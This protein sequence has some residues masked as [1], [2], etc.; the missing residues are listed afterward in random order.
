MSEKLPQPNLILPKKGPQTT[1]EVEI[2]PISS[3]QF[4]DIYQ[5]DVSG[6]DGN[7]GMDGHSYYGSEGGFLSF[8]AGADGKHGHPGQPG[9][10]GI[11][12]GHITVGLRLAQTEPETRWGLPYDRHTLLQGHFKRPSAQRQNASADLQLAFNPELLLHANGGQGGRGGDGGRGQDGARGYHGRNATRYSN[13][14]NG[15]PGGDG[16][17]GGR[18]GDGGLGGD[19]GDIVVGV[20]AEQS[21]LLMLVE[22]EVKGGEGGGGGTGGQGG[23][24]GP[25]GS[26]G[27]SYS[28]RE[29]AGND[30]NGNPRYVTR[31]NS[32]GISGRRG[33]NGRRGGDGYKAADG[34]DGSITLVLQNAQGQPIQKARHCFD[35]AIT[36][37][38][39]RDAYGDQIWEPGERIYLSE[40]TVQN[41]GQIPLPPQ[42]NAYLYL[43]NNDRILSEAIAL[44]LPPSLAPGAA[45]TFA[46]ELAVHLRRPKDS[47]ITEEPFRTTATIDPGAVMGGIQKTFRN[48][49][50]NTDLPVQFPI[51]SGPIYG[52]HAIAKGEAT[53]IKW[54][55]ANHSATDQGYLSEMKRQIETHFRFIPSE[56]PDALPWEHILLFDKFGRRMDIPEGLVQE[57]P[58]LFAKE[59][60]EAANNILEQAAFIAIHPDARPMTTAMSISELRFAHPDHPDSLERIQIP[61]FQVRVAKKY[62]KTPGSD[63][64]LV[65]NKDTHIRTVQ[66]VLAYYK[67][68][69]SEVDIW[70]VAH[71]GLLNLEHQQENG[72]SLM[73]DFEGKTV[74]ILNND[75]K[76][77]QGSE[78]YSSQLVDKRQFLRAANDYGINF[79]LLGRTEFQGED[80]RDALQIPSSE[81]E[82]ISWYDGRRATR[83]ALKRRIEEGIQTDEGVLSAPLGDIA[84][85]VDNFSNRAIGWRASGRLFLWA[86][87]RF[88]AKR[89]RKKT[90]QLLQLL[91]KRYPHER[92]IGVYDW[93]VKEKG[94]VLGGLWGKVEWGSVIFR[95]GPHRLHGGRMVSVR[96]SEK[97]LVDGSFFKTPDAPFQ[98]AIGLTIWESRELFERFLTEQSEV[99]TDPASRATFHRAV[100]YHI[101]AEQANLRMFKW[102]SL[103]SK[104]LEKNLVFFR[105]LTSFSLGFNDITSPQ[106][107]FFGNVFAHALALNESFGYKLNFLFP[108]HRNLRL[109]RLVRRMVKDWVDRN[110]DTSGEL[111]RMD[112]KLW[113][114]N[115]EQKAAFLTGMERRKDQILERLREDVGTWQARGEALLQRY[116]GDV[117]GGERSKNQAYSRAN[118]EAIKLSDLSRQNW[119]DH[120]EDSETEMIRDMTY[121]LQRTEIEGRETWQVQMEKGSAETPFEDG[122]AD[123]EVAMADTVQPDSGMEGQVVE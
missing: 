35:L 25:G 39:L 5:I 22:A 21:H 37:Y 64:L 3:L 107:E 83:R 72:R 7:R 102:T 10:P 40:L 33:A 110:F 61:A 24:G 73:Q 74:L 122:F 58:L 88:S 2:D 8:Q 34:P 69:G 4:Q 20:P 48:A 78:V 65:I 108:R 114:R 93:D 70:D 38:V 113:E 71:Y 112:R 28:W 36:H 119:L 111:K 81:P 68:L 55:L 23:D 106:A 17:D 11:D 84:L 19:G 32:G 90:E 123:N 47:E 50:R 95:Q 41:T 59:E 42:R 75:F 120:F 45:Y 54:T 29:R 6:P 49:R 79:Y 105:L 1:E 85:P 101:A 51:H 67:M 57:V 89:L 115:V 98:L 52:H 13:G 109:T 87:W 31:S 76:S 62:L 16:G 117:E 46:E 121:F 26:G 56:D 82:S 14:G 30:S 44:R 96:A 27:S 15:G 100:M 43:R 94:L 77:N 99:L 63:I 118:F 53:R 18:G 66:D 104:E 91:Q 103:S 12:A 60:A 97:S 86:R 9:M 92:F 80:I 116:L